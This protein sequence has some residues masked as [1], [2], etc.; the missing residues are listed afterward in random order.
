MHAD[1]ISQKSQFI[2]LSNMNSHRDPSHVLPAY[3]CYK[4]DW[5]DF[6]Q[7]FGVVLPAD[8]LYKLHAQANCRD[9]PNALENRNL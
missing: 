4:I 1:Y 9:K 5:Q 3:Y 2:A 8:K 6:N 7:F